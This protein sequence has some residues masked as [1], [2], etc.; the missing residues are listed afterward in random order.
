MGKQKIKD[1]ERREKKKEGKHEKVKKEPEEKPKS[2]ADA[3]QI[4]RF[5]ETNLDGR[6]PVSTVIRSVRGVG[7]IFGN[8]VSHVSG[9]GEKKMGDLSDEELKHLENI[10]MNPAKYNIPSW[11]FNRKKDPLSGEARHLSVSQLELATRMDINE[12]KKLR[13]YKGVRHGLG[14]PVRGQRTRSSFRKSGKV[15]GV[16]KKKAR[17]ATAKKKV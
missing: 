9:L 10:I 16:S 4:I 7:F 13:T 5:A 15:V 17:P 1:L 11:M 8:A 6:L 3:K 2:V 12:M 14:L